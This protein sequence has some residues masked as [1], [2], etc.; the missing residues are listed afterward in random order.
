M[1]ATR[2]AE[3]RNLTS[4]M[5]PSCTSS[6]ANSGMFSSDRET[7]EGEHSVGARGPEPF[8]QPQ[9]G[10]PSWE[11]TPQAMVS[12]PPSSIRSYLKYSFCAPMCYCPVTFPT[13][14][15]VSHR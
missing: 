2:A 5:K 1:E 13:P 7:G 10:Y 9:L 4:L 15:K 11:R 12:D 6:A 3:G 14:T 8:Q